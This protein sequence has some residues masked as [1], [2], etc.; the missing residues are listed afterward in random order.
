VTPNVWIA[1]IDWEKKNAIPNNWALGDIP[2]IPPMN[3]GEPK[4]TRLEYARPH[5]K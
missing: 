5:D 3:E 1:L 2:H 4:M